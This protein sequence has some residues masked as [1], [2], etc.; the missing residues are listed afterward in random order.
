MADKNITLEEQ[1]V[2]SAKDAVKSL[3]DIISAVEGVKG[4]VKDAKNE[5]I[6]LAS[7]F[8]SSLS[9][10]GKS[11]GALFSLRK[12]TKFIK[13]A[14]QDA[15]DLIE[16]T[17]L[18]EVSFG[19]GMGEL[20]KYY[21]EA[22]K[23]QNELSEKLG[24]NLNESM[25]FQALFNSMGTSMGLDRGT[26]YT[27]SKNFT[28]L[29]YDLASLYNT[30]TD[31]AMEKLQS[32]LSGASTRPL[33]AFG[34]DITQNTL[35][36]TLADLGIDR[37]IGDLNQAEKMVL[38]YIS[39]IKQASVAH[40]DFAR[41]LE[42]PANQLRIF[43]AQLLALKQ[44]L[45]TL[46]QGVL[47]KWMPY[48]NAMLMVINALIKAIASFFGIK[49]SSSVQKMS[50]S[51]DNGASGASGISSGLG[52]ANKKAKD[53]KETLDLMPWDEIHNID[54]G[55]DTSSSSGGGGVSGGGGGASIDQGLLD[56]MKAMADYDNLID[57][58]NNKATSLRDKWMDWLGFT[59][60]INEETGEIE[61][62]LKEGYQ[63]IELIRD[64][65]AGIA[66]GLL[67]KKIAKLFFTPSQLKQFDEATTG[68][69]KLRMQAGAIVMA[70]GG[71]SI[72]NGLNDN[73]MKEK[74][75]GVLE[76]GAGAGIFFKSWKAGVVGIE[77]AG[78][79]TLVVS[80]V[81]W[82]M[83]NYE[84]SKD[85]IGKVE[86]P[87]FMKGA[88]G[89]NEEDQ[90]KVLQGLTQGQ[91]SWWTGYITEFGKAFGGFSEEEMLEGW[92]NY[93][94]SAHEGYEQWVNDVGEDIDRFNAKWGEVTDTLDGVLSD[95]LG[96]K[97]TW[98]EYMDTITDPSAWDSYFQDVETGAGLWRDDML[99]TILGF[100]TT[101]EEYTSTLT[102]PSAWSQYWQDV[103]TG[104]GIWKDDMVAKYNEFK[105]KAS[106][107]ISEFK[108]K[109]SEKFG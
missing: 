58:V 4:S 76:V 43:Q 77:I 105:E 70:I 89:V 55:T 10:V 34:I 18:F 103:K 75:L 24:T 48:I 2:V 51:L 37:K 80:S 101:W 15:M 78:A 21:Q 97:T 54:L 30:E 63:K 99:S 46:W 96:F 44:N 88:G 64:I 56:A 109:A 33:R 72:I 102:D 40:G 20:N 25:N 90:Q 28:K 71:I 62:K 27:I 26:A 60:L 42:S 36:N 92:D 7:A 16:T 74:L 73:D 69:E 59:K 8:K 61:W 66:T 32:G 39:V 107:K 106:L 52:S 67:A 9:S 93:L 85:V 17:N 23:F 98:E 31:K 3:E 38:R 49:V 81:D 104:A 11:V 6:G 100:D 47:Q 82:I 13:E 12:L 14:N 45:G 95:V 35:S 29:G 79:I 50:V 87:D 68:L 108:E 53:L 86:V 41:T 94:A 19:K 57:Q 91:Y 1:I 5:S 22:I 83:D 65:L 84:H